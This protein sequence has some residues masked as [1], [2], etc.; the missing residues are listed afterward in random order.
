MYSI[1]EVQI[2]TGYG[3]EFDH[4]LDGFPVD[5]GK[6]LMPGLEVRFH[7]SGGIS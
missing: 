3:V 4:L 1:V 7:G 6:A 5:V 2:K